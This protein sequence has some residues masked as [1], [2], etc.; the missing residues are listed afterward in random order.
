MR[1]FRLLIIRFYWKIT[2]RNTFELYQKLLDLEFTTKE[3]WQEYQLTLINEL[4]M[5]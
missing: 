4:L 2:G 1:F 5:S 3:K